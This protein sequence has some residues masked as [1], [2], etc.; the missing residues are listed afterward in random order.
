MNQGANQRNGIDP[1]PI[2]TSSL[3]SLISE[4]DGS[5]LPVSF[6]GSGLTIIVPTIPN[7]SCGSQTYS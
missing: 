3:S 1:S 7:A 4:G 6:T 2:D 5:E